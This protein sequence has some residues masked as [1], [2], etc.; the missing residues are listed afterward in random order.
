MSGSKRRPGFFPGQLGIPALEDRL[1]QGPDARVG[2][3]VAVVFHRHRAP[4][5]EVH[6]AGEE[7]ADPDVVGHHLAAVPPGDVDRLPPLVRRPELEIDARGGGPG[8]HLH[9]VRR[10]EPAVDPLALLEGAG[11][12]VD[13]RVSR[14]AIGD[15]LLGL[16]DGVGQGRGAGK[17]GRLGR[18]ARDA[19]GV[20][21]PGAVLCRRGLRRRGFGPSV[22]HGQASQADRR[23][24]RGQP[25]GGSP[26]AP[27]APLGPAAVGRK[28][29][30]DPHGKSL[31]WHPAR[32]GGRGAVEAGP[33]DQRTWAVDRVGSTI[34]LRKRAV[35]V[36]SR[37]NGGAELGVGGG[38][39]TLSLQFVSPHEL[40]VDF[41]N[42]TRDNSDG[43][44]FARRSGPAHC[45]SCNV[46]AHDFTNK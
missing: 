3:R 7:L 33:V 1:D 2:D 17:V 42:L 9:D 34:H 32:A 10:R 27:G 11:V 25:A 14:L 16:G 43:N 46:A 23:D 8:L 39:V 18:P 26:S 41:V 19:R 38:S 44:D 24:P 5:V 35:G 21:H 6:R 36:R 15:G 12:V 13:P 29:G 45:Q 4:G 28:T 37:W 40:P 30:R 20:D 22:L 31:S